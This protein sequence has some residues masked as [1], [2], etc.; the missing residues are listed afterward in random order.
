[1]LRSVIAGAAV[2]AIALTG[3]GSAKDTSS[4]AQVTSAATSAVAA[5]TNVPGYTLRRAPNAIGGSPDSIAPEGKAKI[6][7]DG[8]VS[9]LTGPVSCP[10]L[11]TEF[12]LAIGS[13]PK[14]A[15]VAVQLTKGSSPKAK[16]VGI[17]SRNIIVSVAD[18]SGVKV[19]KT[20][21]NYVVT[22]EGQRVDIEK[23]DTVTDVP[24]TIDATCPAE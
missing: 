2:L 4:A 17:I 5:A 15:Y 6:T 23:M 12:Y 24:F 3:C 22:G 13:D 18:G 19:V 9:K 11:E 8:E 10:A 20:G 16:S 14:V 7:V 1:M 21:D